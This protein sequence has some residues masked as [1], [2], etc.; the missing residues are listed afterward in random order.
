MKTL[1]LVAVICLFAAT[2]IG[3]QKENTV[4]DPRRNHNIE[5]AK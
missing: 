1:K 3:C 2:F 5:H 4:A